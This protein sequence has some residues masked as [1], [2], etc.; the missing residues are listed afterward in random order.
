MIGFTASCILIK[1]IESHCSGKTD[2]HEQ[3]V[4]N[5]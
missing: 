5:K 3:D 1:Q 2:V 4:A